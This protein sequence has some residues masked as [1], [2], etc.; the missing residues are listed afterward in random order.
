M[1]IVIVKRSSLS[2]FSYFWS[3]WSPFVIMHV[4]LQ[5]CNAHPFFVGHLDYQN[6]YATVMSH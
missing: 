4:K 1:V 5:H 6:M 2:L 3:A